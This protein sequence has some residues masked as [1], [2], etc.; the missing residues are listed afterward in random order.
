MYRRVVAAAAP[1]HLI[2]AGGAERKRRV[3]T[4]LGRDDAAD[5]V[6]NLGT[7]ASTLGDAPVSPLAASFAGRVLLA[8]P[9]APRPP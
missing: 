9:V 6:A 2:Q 7:P 3:Q 8:E 5:L 4:V 1:V